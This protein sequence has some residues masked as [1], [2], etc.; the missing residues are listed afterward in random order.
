MPDSGSRPVL[1]DNDRPRLPVSQ[2]PRPAAGQVAPRGETLDALL[3]CGF[4]PTQAEVAA[5]TEAVLETLAYLGTF[6]P[7]VV[8][9]DITPASVVFDRAS[10]AVALIGFGHA[11]GQQRPGDGL[12]VPPGADAKAFGCAAPETFCGA[13]R[14]TRTAEPSSRAPAGTQPPAAIERTA[15][16]RP[17]VQVDPRS[18][19]FSLGG[20]MLF[21]ITGRSLAEYPL[22]TDLADG[23]GDAA[24]A[25]AEPADA[26]PISD[27]AWLLGGERP[28]GASSFSASSP[29]AIAWG[30]SGGGALLGR[31]FALMNWLLATE[32]SERPQSA[33][34]ALLLLRLK[35]ESKLSTAA[36]RLR[37]PAGS[38]ITVRV[39]SSEEERRCAGAGG[40]AR[41]AGGVVVS[42]PPAITRAKLDGFAVSF[43]T[44]CILVLLGLLW[45]TEPAASVVTA[46]MGFVA[47]VVA[48]LGKENMVA[49][50]ARSF[51][52]L[53]LWRLWRDNRNVNET[54]AGVAAVVLGGTEFRP[55]IWCHSRAPCAVG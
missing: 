13:V 29:P 9:R 34:D 40:Q 44:V 43:Y 33:A 4:H 2:A 48:Q 28:D 37:P 47:A 18:D 42:V 11:A 22:R 38:G 51:A 7:P 15:A 26:E 14:M 45:A 24:L 35:A 27:G 49:G 32:P 52:L 41:R 1:E 46:V 6:L 8:H 39:V 20:T 19:L 17:C 16:W 3:R 53:P 55:L 30:A 23:L 31:L 36:A 54:P 10:G 12:A 50:V 21:L 5:I 25:D